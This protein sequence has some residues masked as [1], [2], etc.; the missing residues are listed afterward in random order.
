MELLSINVSRPKTAEHRGKQI[1]TGIFKT[2][3]EGRRTVRNTNIDGDGQ[4]DLTVHGGVNKAVYVFPFEHYSWYRNLL[5]RR[6]LDFGYFG[7]N[8]TTDGLLENQVRIGDRFQ[9][10]EAIFEVSQPRSPCFK[11]AM[12]VGASKI[13]KPF[14]S[15]GRT[16]FYFRVVQEGNIEAR[17]AIERIYSDADAPT[18]NEITRLYYFERQDIAGLRKAIGTGALSEVWRRDFAKRLERL[19]RL[20]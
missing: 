5:E 10:G 8:L 17:N 15:S 20:R 2:P 18:V 16:G 11:L 7:E 14:L 4:A 12:K 19:A 9:I 6:D 1:S 3:I 13:L